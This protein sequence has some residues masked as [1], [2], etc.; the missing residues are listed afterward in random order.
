MFLLLMPLVVLVVGIAYVSRYSSIDDP[1]IDPRLFVGYLGA[2]V[3]VGAVTVGWAQLRWAAE[4]GRIREAFGRHLGVSATDLDRD[5]RQRVTTPVPCTALNLSGRL[6]E[7]RD[8]KRLWLCFL[9]GRLLVASG[10]TGQ[11][12]EASENDLRQLHLVDSADAGRFQLAL[13]RPET[14]FSLLTVTRLDDLVRV[15]NVLIKQGV[16]LRHLKRA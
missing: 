8:R 3:A 16:A 13:G 9:P 4:R 10:V 2:L 7:M 12:V 14:G 15:V 1:F 6:S 5:L 11:V